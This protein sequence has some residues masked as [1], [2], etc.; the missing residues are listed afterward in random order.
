VSDDAALDVLRRALEGSFDR[1]LIVAAHP[2]DET[3]GAGIAMSRMRNVAVLHMTDGAPRDRNFIAKSFTG[4]V[5][6]YAQVRAREVREALAL[7]GVTDIR[8]LACPDLE[9][10]YRLPALARGVGEVV[11][12]VRPALVITHGYEG[13][14]PDHDAAAF[15]V[16]FMECGGLPP[17]SAEMALYHAHKDGLAA[18][19]FL[20]TAVP[21]LTI[22]LTAGERELKRR[23]FACFASQHE[24]LAPFPFETERFRAAPRYNFIEP[25]HPGPLWYEI[26]RWPM[27]GNEWRRLAAE[28]IG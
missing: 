26:L 10:M 4:S 27:T 13:G 28:A 16:Q 12:E 21:Q 19:T 15:A 25:P 3:I 20:D 24:V 8:S 23:M 5:E 7:A 22:E 2:D 11:R 17:P 1:V 9:A 14:H 18:G 6:D